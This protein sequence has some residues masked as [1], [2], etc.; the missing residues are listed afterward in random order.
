[1][2][3]RSEEGLSLPPSSGGADFCYFGLSGALKRLIHPS[4]CLSHWN[5]LLSLYRPFS[6]PVVVGVIPFKNR[7]QGFA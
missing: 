5:P 2:F 3:Y 1:M 7:W 6:G 4:P